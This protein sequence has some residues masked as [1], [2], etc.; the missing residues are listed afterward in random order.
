MAKGA[1]SEDE[2]LFSSGPVGWEDHFAIAKWHVE[3]TTTVWGDPRRAQAVENEESHALL[4]CAYS[5]KIIVI[6]ISRRSA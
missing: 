3:R 6:L 1:Y 4:D 5:G 2:T